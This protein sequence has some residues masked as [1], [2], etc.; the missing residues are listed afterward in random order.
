MGTAM[1]HKNGDATD[2]FERL[3]GGRWRALAAQTAQ[4]LAITPETGAKGY[5]CALKRLKDVL[6]IMPGDCEGL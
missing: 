2:Q 6:A 4:V 1:D 5:V 3:R